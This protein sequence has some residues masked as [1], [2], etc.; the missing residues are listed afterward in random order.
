METPSPTWPVPWP[1]RGSRVGKTAFP[2]AFPV[3]S[4]TTIWM[5][6]SVSLFPPSTAVPSGSS[7]ADWYFVLTV[8]ALTAFFREPSADANWN[9][10]DSTVINPLI[11][12]L[13]PGLRIAGSPGDTRI[14]C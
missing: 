5:A 13:S 4:I 2:N 1:R 12:I 7:R 6:L 14:S 11:V 10:P 9:P 3:L 8:A